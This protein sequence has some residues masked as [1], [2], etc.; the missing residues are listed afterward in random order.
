MPYH[1]QIKRHPISQPNWWSS[2]AHMVHHKSYTLT[3]VI[4]SKV[5]CLLKLYML[6]VFA[7][8]E[9][10]HTNLMVERFN[11]TMLQFLWAYISSQDEWE[12]YLPFVLYP[13]RTSQHTTTGVSP[14]ML[15]YGRQPMSGPMATQLGYDSLSY[16]AQIQSRLAELRDFVH[17]QLTQ[18]A[19]SQ[20]LHYDLHTK[21]PTLF[22]C[23]QSSVV[24]NP[25][26][27]ET[28]LTLGGKGSG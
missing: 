1:F 16:S 20:K 2:L 11:R 14:F 23:R 24:V 18:A 28:Y 19:H 6:S 22:C 26:S 8:Y 12:T 4:T 5:Q 10:H 21:Q 15:L 27:R 3:K 17:T 7:N 25:H 9:L 13:Y